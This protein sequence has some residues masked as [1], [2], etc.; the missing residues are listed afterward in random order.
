M[1]FDGVGMISP[2]LA[3]IAS[4][5]GPRAK[6]LSLQYPRPST[7][8][9]TVSSVREGSFEDDIESGGDPLICVR[10]PEYPDSTPRIFK[11]SFDRCNCSTS[12][13]YE[14]QCAH[15]IKVRDGYD[16]TYFQIRHKRRN[17]VKGSLNGWSFKTDKTTSGLR[18]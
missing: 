10:C 4:D 18:K 7:F 8:S 9:Q 14:A 15:E 12:V 11:T 16:P 3:L 1:R 6:G 17:Q 13:A 2:L 5:S